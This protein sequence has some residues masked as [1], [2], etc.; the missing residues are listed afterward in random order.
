MAREFHKL[1]GEDLQLGTD[2]G[3]KTAPGG[4]TLTGTKIGIHTFAVGGVAVEAVWDIPTA[5]PAGVP[6]GGKI[7]TTV[8]VPGAALKD[9]V[10]RSFSLDLQELTL[11][12]DVI[13]DNTVEVVLG[14]LTGAVVYP[15]S[16]TIRVAVLKC[17]V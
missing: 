6:A 12:A 17:K 7:S 10:L 3:T 8:T 13:S 5:F 4:G 1:L 2:A 11:T 9:F 16:G 14:N 15:G